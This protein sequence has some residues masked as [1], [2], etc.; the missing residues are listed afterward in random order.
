[1]SKPRVLIMAGGTGG[2][3]F[4]GL[5]VADRMR[6]LG[7][8]INWLG[9]GRGIENDLVPA[10]GYPLHQL[11]VTGVRGSSAVARLLAPFRIAQSVWQ[12]MRTLRHFKP[13]VVLGFGGYASG[14]GGV[15]ARLLRIPLVIHEQNAVAG[16]T[17]KLLSRIANSVLCGFP[18][19]FGPA[20]QCTV[21]GNP[22]RASLGEI[23]SPTARGLAMQ[24]P[25]R[26]LI[27]G[28]SQGAQAINEM[29][30]EALSLLS[31]SERPQ[32][33]HQCGKA[34]LVATQAAYARAAVNANIEPFIT[35]MAEAL[36]QADLVIA[37]AGALTVAEIA[38]VGVSSVLIPFPHAIDDHQTSNARALVDLGAATLMPQSG[39]TAEALAA[40]LREQLQTESLLSRATAS[41]AAGKPDA[42]EQ[43]VRELQHWMGEKV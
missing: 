29:V 3:V 38:A 13:D 41:R 43:V 4:P 6:D 34:N 10:A 12:A 23:D 25:F 22:V 14:P 21:V 17:N 28:G 40:T 42:T 18:N 36:T 37:R 31:P 32:V 8:E 27:L 20:V 5:A 11:T 30:P 2:H 39:L 19:A 9:T 7:Y 16:T 33:R 35:D 1:M 26:L 24:T 15:A